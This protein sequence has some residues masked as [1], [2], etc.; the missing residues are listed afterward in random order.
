M[1]KSIQVK[2]VDHPDKLI[3]KAKQEAKKNGI[4]FLGDADRGIIRGFGIEADYVLQD[5]LL[6]V[7]V[8]RKPMLLPWAKVEQKVR[9][10]VDTGASRIN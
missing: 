7:T 4:Q 9:T 6:T 10:F 5:E 2:I 1:P 3:N 8:F